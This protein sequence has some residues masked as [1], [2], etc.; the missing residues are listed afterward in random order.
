MSQL[1]RIPAGWFLMGDDEGRDDERPVH[2]VWVDAF[3]M[4]VSPVTRT[5]FERFVITT[6]RETPRD[7]ALPQFG[8]PDL[9]VVGVSWHDATAYAAWLS[10]AEPRVRLP[11][12]AEWERAARG[13]LEQRRYAW[14]NQ[15]PFWIPNHGRGP[16]PGPWRVTLGEP[17]EYGVYG[18]G[19]NVH[20]WCADWYQADYYAVTPDRNPGGPASGVRRTSRGGSWRHA[21]TLSRSAARSRLDPSFRYTD[22]GF[23]LVRSVG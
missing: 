18:I 11:S 12:E 19:A 4:A 16:L 7:W 2:R 3:E 20:E 23:R 13:G 10:E 21:I 1:V 17:N 9:P 8:A 14:G 5:E 22:Y 15:I 6:G